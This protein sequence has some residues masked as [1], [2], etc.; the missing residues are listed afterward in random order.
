MALPNLAL[1]SLQL[2]NP[3]EDPHR[4]HLLLWPTHPHHVGQHD[5][6]FSWGYR[7]RPTYQCIDGA[8]HIVE[9]FSGHGVCTAGDC[10]A[11]RNVWSQKSVGGV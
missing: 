5:R 2:A 4:H 1:K 6:A 9:L 7:R 8:N 3:S 10:G 11:E